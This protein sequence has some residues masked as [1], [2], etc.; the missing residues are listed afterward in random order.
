[1]HIILINIIIIIINYIKLIKLQFK[2]SFNIDNNHL[3]HDHDIR[4]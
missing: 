2:K 1:M 3:Q 4:V